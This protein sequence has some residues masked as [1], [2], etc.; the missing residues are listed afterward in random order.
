MNRRTFLKGAASA[1]LGVAAVRH[2]P[3]PS[4]PVVGVD[5]GTYEGS[6]LV[7]CGTGGRLWIDETEV[8]S[9]NGE[10]EL[11]GEFVSSW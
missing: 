9:W 10:F 11:E 4:E 3:K 2:L 1:A 8:E 5:L 6:R 7:G